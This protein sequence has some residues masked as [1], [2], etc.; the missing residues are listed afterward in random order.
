MDRPAELDLPLDV[1]DFSPTHTCGC[2]D[3]RRLSEAELPQR[4]HRQPVDLPH[5]LTAGIDEYG[6]PLDV[7]LDQAADSIYP[8]DAHLD[9]LG[10]VLCRYLLPACLSRPV[11]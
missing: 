8:T 7:L 10:H 9:G 6:P 4:Q 2:G 5:V 3:T 11:V 1:D